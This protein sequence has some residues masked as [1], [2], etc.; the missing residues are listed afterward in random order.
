VSPQVFA[1]KHQ[2]GIDHTPTVDNSDLDLINADKAFK[3]RDFV[4]SEI[5]YNKILNSDIYNA[6]MNAILYVKLGNSQKKLGKFDV[7]FSSYTKAKKLNKDIK[8]IDYL[9]KNFRTPVGEKY[10][11]QVG[12]FLSENNANNAIKRLNFSDGNLTLRKIHIDGYYQVFFDGF[13]DIT[14]AK[15]TLKRL[16]DR[17]NTVNFFFKAEPVS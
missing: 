9:I 13:T 4:Q 5:L 6:K 16:K 15:D 3:D 17:N 10:T 2:V 14:D 1:D 12:S 8:N 7:A 11:I